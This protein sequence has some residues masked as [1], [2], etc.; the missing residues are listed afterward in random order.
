MYLRGGVRAKGWSQS[1]GVG[2]GRGQGQRMESQ[3][4]GEVQVKLV[5]GQW[6]ESESRGR[7]KTGP[8]LN[9]QIALSVSR[10]MGGEMEPGPFLPD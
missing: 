8:C 4:R 1:Q 9:I 7:V 10:P 3:L 6:E 5:Q 2:E